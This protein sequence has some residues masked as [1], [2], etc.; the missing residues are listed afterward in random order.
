MW[1]AP[2]PLTP[3]KGTPK[4]A[5]HRKRADGHNDLMTQES[6]DTLP[7]VGSRGEGPERQEPLGGGASAGTTAPG[8][9][10]VGDDSTLGE[11]SDY[12][13]VGR[14]ADGL[15]EGELPPGLSSTTPV[16]D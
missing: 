6:S 11:G 8:G 5:L 13:D 12:A 16:D 2:R 14:S 3:A 1:V 10:L 7:S 9:G 15:D 4:S